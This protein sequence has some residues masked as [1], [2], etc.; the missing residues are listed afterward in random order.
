MLIIC[1]ITNVAKELTQGAVIARHI[2]AARSEYR[3]SAK[4]FPTLI[5]HKFVVL[6]NKMLNGSEVTSYFATLLTLNNVLS[7]LWNFAEL[8]FDL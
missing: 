7:Y 8:L 5:L 3:M 1:N 6:T 2:S 4:Y